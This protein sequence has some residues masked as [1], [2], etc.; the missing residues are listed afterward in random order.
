MGT[1]FACY[2]ASCRRRGDKRPRIKGDPEVA[3]RGWAALSLGAGRCYAGGKATFP[4]DI[5]KHRNITSLEGWCCPQ[6]RLGNYLAS[7]TPR[8]RDHPCRAPHRGLSLLPEFAMPNPRMTAA[9]IRDALNDV[10]TPD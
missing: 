4:K 5:R 9:P 7:H 8:V 10:V 1:P 2:S 3:I 6:A